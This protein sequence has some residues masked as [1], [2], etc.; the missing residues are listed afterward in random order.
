MHAIGNLIRRD[1]ESL[2]SWKVLRS[3]RM[4]VE[5]IRRVVDPLKNHGLPRL[6]TN[7]TVEFLVVSFS[8]FFLLLRFWRIGTVPLGFHSDE[9]VALAN[10]ICLRHTG[11]DLWGNSWSFFSGG[12]VNGAGYSVGA[13][14][15]LFAVYSLWLYLVGDSIAAARSF[16]VL[17]SLIIVACTVGIANN[18]LGRRGALW[19]LGLS[20]ISPWTWSLSRVAFVTPNFLSMH[21]FVGL[22][23]ITRHLRRKTGP[24]NL[25]VTASGLLL[26]M[27]ASRYYSALSTVMIAGFISWYLFRRDEPAKRPLVFIGAITATFFAMQLGLS[28]YSAKRIAQMSIS[29]ELRNESSV[30]G[31]VTTVIRITWENL[32]QH[33]SPNFLIFH[34]DSNRRQHSGWG[35]EL[36]WPQILLVALVPVLIVM[37]KRQP[38]HYRRERQLALVASLGAAGGLLTSSATGELVNA[39]RALVSAP[40]LILLCVVVG[41][42]VSARVPLLIVL[43]IGSGLIYF[44]LFANNYFSDYAMSSAR[45]FHSDIRLAG[46]EARRTGDFGAFWQRLPEFAKRYGLQSEVGLVFYEAAGS[47]RGCPGYK[48]K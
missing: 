25:E 28:K 3:K 38:A 10:S 1:S 16:E 37:L 48:S 18:F 39:N 32:L 47:G 4:R 14:S 40:F 11:V 35:G 33:L 9:S 12:P 34:G 20:A 22:W 41:S 27:A 2:L 15:H 26:G 6:K 29:D 17:I 5:K 44:G 8:L 36:S 42:V 31:K 13:P 24:S 43:A 19:A 21:L 23:V 45:P 46:E 7:S 30:L